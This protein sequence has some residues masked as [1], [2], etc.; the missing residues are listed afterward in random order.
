MKWS[1][2]PLLLAVV[3]LGIPLA[4]HLWMSLG[5]RLTGPASTHLAR[6]D[7]ALADG[8]YAEAIIAY[9]RAQK[10]DPQSGPADLGLTRARVHG[11]ADEPSRLRDEHVDELR[12]D[13]SLLLER[14]PR[15]AAAC[16][17]AL[18]HL[19][20]RQGDITGA[21]AKY[22]EALKVDSAS[23]LA[24]TALGNA[25]LNDKDRAPQAAAEFEAAL[26][27]R[28]THV[29]A[30]LGLAKMAL[31]KGETEP[32]I[33]HLTAALAVRDNYNAHLLLGNVQIHLKN[34]NDGI[35]HLERAVKLE[36]QS[37]EALRSLGQALMA[38]DRSAEAER[39]LRAAA[40]MSDDIEAATALG[41]SLARQRKHG[42][43]LEA[44]MQVIARAPDAPL[45]LF[46]AGVALE[47]LGKRDEA[48]TTYRR[49]LR[50]KAPP[51]RELP[52]LAQVTDDAKQRLAALEA[53][54]PDASADKN[55]AAGP[56]PPP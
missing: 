36:P 18:G 14:D 24:H 31:A 5:D 37:G 13:T 33:K 41:F 46:G 39:P 15:S 19:A 55:A 30:L 3:L 2:A 20:G 47:E 8:R 43:A 1:G 35:A 11:V 44:F 45:A 22:E 56:P 50:L 23:P 42:A 49:L 6:G 34:L 38:A 21:K 10:I 32:A 12:Y 4:A 26:K 29:G 52:G 40:Q 53:A 51:G 7:K 16:H 25:Y 17:V 27:L 54:S 9:G 28:P 48:A